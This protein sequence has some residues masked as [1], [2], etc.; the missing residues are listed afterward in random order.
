[1]K[2]P[3]PQGFA[4]RL[5]APLCVF[6]GPGMGMLARRVPVLGYELRSPGDVRHAVVPVMCRHCGGHSAAFREDARL[7]PPRP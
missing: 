5:L 6:C 2:T 7:P 4:A 1:M 3:R